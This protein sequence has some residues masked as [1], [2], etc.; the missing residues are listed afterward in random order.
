MSVYVP[1]ARP[2]PYGPIFVVDPPTPKPEP[3]PMPD[4]KPDLRGIPRDQIV[5]GF[6]AIDAYLKANPRLGAADG[7]LPADGPLSSRV[8][9]ICAYGVSEFL[10]AF[11]AGGPL[12]GDGPGYA[13]RRDAALAHTFQVIERE[14]GGNPQ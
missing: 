2:Q 9:R 7:L 13:A 8:D 11:Q 14:H 12:P 3:K 5:L 10:G 1:P 6:E 4:T